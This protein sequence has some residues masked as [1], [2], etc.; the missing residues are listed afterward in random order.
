MPAIEALSV[1]CAPARGGSRSAL[2]TVPHRESALDSSLS[3]PFGLT[4]FAWRSA[5]GAEF[6]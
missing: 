2:P 1:E 4:C 5:P 6:A 3:L